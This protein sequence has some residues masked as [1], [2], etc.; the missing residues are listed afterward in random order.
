M[1][2]EAFVTCMKQ[3]TRPT[4]ARHANISQTSRYL[5][6]TTPGEDEAMRRFEERS[7]PID[8]D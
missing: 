3:A 1:A 6:T 4:S 7:W 2:V 8:T 5:A